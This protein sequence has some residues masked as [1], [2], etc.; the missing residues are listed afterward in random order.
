MVHDRRWLLLGAVSLGLLLITLD[1]SILYTALP[2][3]TEELGASPT[4]SLWIINAYP[5]VMAGLLLGAGTLGDRAGHRRM[6]VIGLVTFGV[7][8]IVAAFAPTPAVLI[9]ARAMLAVGAAAMMPATLALIRIG[10]PDARERNLAIAVWGSISVLGMAL[11]P[12][13]SGVLLSAFWWGSV[14]LVNVPVVLLSLA[15]VPFVLPPNDADS[16]RRWDLSSS[17]LA[18]AALVG[19]VLV[20]KEIAKPQPAWW[21]VAVALLLCVAGAVLFVRRQRRLDDPLLDFSVFGNAAFSSG[22]TAAALVMFA[23]AGVQLITTQRFQLVAGF[24]PLE[25]GLLMAAVAIGSLPTALLGGAALHVTG[26]RIPVSGGMALAAVGALV[27]G[28]S[29]SGSI[30][31]FVVGLVILGAGVGLVFAV[32]STAIV[33]NVV[34]QRAGM[35]SSL[36][37]VSYEFGSLVAIALVGTLMTTIYSA[38]VI[39]P[40][41]SPA[42]AA[43][44]MAAAAHV[45]A[46]DPVLLRAAGAA[47]DLS[48]RVI[49]LGI[50]A[51]LVAGSAITGWMLRAHGPRTESTLAEVAH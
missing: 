45:A 19:L 6:F 34:R 40:A 11:G 29:V 32:A 16:S 24:T 26:L 36:E 1:N 14:F 42:E 43:E 17:V 7:A 51:L 9:A 46:G 2:T 12:V 13:L 35:A 33:G 38:T 3:L 30:G 5:L 37:E 44:S 15:A 28:L 39:V 18:M 21:L 49:A 48:Y 41:G 10:F 47:F 23:V 20:I 27:A 22:I 31:P 4:E 25:S 50:A 8:S